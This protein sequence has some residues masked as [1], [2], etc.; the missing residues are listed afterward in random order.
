M[1]ERLF[2][3]P[4]RS[5]TLSPRQLEVLR[6]VAQGDDG[7]AIAARLVISPETVRWHMRQTLNKLGARNRAHAVALAYHSG[8][9]PPA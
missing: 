5:E 4:R 2:T 8:I 6:L 7:N 9:F 3:G 1:S